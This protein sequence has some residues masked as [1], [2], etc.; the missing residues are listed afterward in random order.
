MAYCDMKIAKFFSQ[1][2]D[3]VVELWY[4]PHGH[5]YQLR[6][7]VEFQSCNGGYSTVATA[8][9]DASD[10]AQVASLMLDAIDIARTPPLERR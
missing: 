6:Y 9:Y 2:Q 3:G 8:S 1:Y 10:N 4:C 7:G 5:S